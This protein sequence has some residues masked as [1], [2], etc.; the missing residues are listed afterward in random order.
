MFPLKTL[1]LFGPNLKIFLQI[2]KEMPN[3]FNN[4]DLPLKFSIILTPPPL[5]TP[6]ALT[7]VLL[8]YFSPTLLLPCRGSRHESGEENSCDADR[9]FCRH[10][11]DVLDEEGVQLDD[12]PQK[13]ELKDGN[14]THPAATGI[15]P[16]TWRPTFGSEL[17]EETIVF[18]L[19]KLK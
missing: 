4:F 2:W 5:N 13:N 3:H 8:W 10:G 1:E 17:K 18:A 16:T 12:L 19:T 9:M 6:G 14:E 15:K 11:E 7:T